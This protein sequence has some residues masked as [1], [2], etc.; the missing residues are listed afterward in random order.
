LKGKKIKDNCLIIYIK[1]TFILIYNKQEGAIK[2]A[3]EA[4]R[5][6]LHPPMSLFDSPQDK[7]RLSKEP[8]EY[9]G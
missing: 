4:Q 9:K 8:V 7:T 3:L 1:I 2:K 6:Y 5:K